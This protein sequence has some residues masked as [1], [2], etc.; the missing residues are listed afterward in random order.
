MPTGIKNLPQ[1]VRAR[2]NANQNTVQKIGHGN[3]LEPAVKEM[4]QED[5]NNLNFEPEKL[6]PEPQDRPSLNTAASIASAN[7]ID[8]DKIFRE[9]TNELAKY[10][11]SHLKVPEIFNPQLIPNPGFCVLH[12]RA[13]KVELAKNDV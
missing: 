8:L 5:S 7:P 13:F 2:E 9:Q 12:L 1:D 6:L 3:A 10:P 4:E 11:T